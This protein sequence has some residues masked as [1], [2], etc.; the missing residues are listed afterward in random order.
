MSISFDDY[1]L[2]E[3]EQKQAQESYDASCYHDWVEQMKEENAHILKPI[4]DEF[5]Y[6]LSFLSFTPKTTREI[7]SRFYD[8]DWNTYY[9]RAQVY[10][11]LTQKKQTY[12]LLDLIIHW[13]KEYKKDQRIP[14]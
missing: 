11:C 9:K 4:E 1:C 3:Q 13:A 8:V 6:L 14:F 7:K 12:Y 5:E 2:E 10:S